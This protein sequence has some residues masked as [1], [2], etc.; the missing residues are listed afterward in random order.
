MA[1]DIMEDA[2]RDGIDVGPDAF[3]VRLITYFES[4]YTPELR[5]HL[6]EYDLDLVWRYVHVAGGTRDNVQHLR[7]ACD[8]LLVD[9]PR[10]GSLLL[11]RAFTRLVLP[12]GDA[13]GFRTD[14]RLGWRLFRDD[15][16]LT[17]AAYASALSRFADQV[18][19][20]DR[21]ARALVDLEI[22]EAHG[23]WL[24]EFNATFLGGLPWM[25]GRAGR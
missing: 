24:K 7:G 25:M 13:D 12:G 6:T 10:N 2:V 4:R 18:E 9:N 3:R 20:L 19:E 23:S 15:R 21:G 1:I 11:L 17:W 14:F 5:P 8:R 16:G 22:T